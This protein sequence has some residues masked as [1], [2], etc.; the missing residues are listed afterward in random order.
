MSVERVSNLESLREVPPPPKDSISCMFVPQLIQLSTGIEVSMQELELL[1]KFKTRT[2]LTISTASNL[3]LYQEEL[4]M[5][6]C[7]VRDQGITSK[8]WC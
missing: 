6:A 7:S 2:G 3:R 8:Q 4:F 1:S 5:L